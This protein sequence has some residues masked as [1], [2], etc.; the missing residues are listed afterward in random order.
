MALDIRLYLTGE[1][2]ALKAG[3][4]ALIEVLLEVAEGHLETVMPGYTHLQRAQPVTLAHHLLAYASM[5]LRDLGRLG[6]CDGRMRVSPLGAGALAGTTYP[7]DRQDVAAR[8]GL[9]GA[10]INSMDA[11]SDRDFA[12]EPFGSGDFDDASFALCR[13]DHPV[14]LL[15]AQVYD[16]GRWVFHR[17][18]HHA[19]K[20]KSRHRGTGARQDRARLRRV[21]GA[22]YHDE[23]A[24]LA[25]NK[26]MQEDKEAVFD[27][28]DTARLCLEVFAPMLKSAVFHPENMRAA[29]AQGF[30]N[31]TDCADY[32]AKKGVPFRDAYAVSGK[33]VALS[34][35]KGVTL[36]ALPLDDYKAAH[37]AF[38]GDVYEA[39]DLI[40][41]VQ[42]RRVDG[43]P[44]PQAV[45]R[46][47]EIVKERL[48]NV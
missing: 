27:A 4:K 45:R 26:D 11:V 43:G 5:L 23:G 48:L 35:E 1:I 18:V 36:E 21:D 22:S 6:D 28:V 17:I 42:Q 31:A 38:D 24:A 9:D 34:I 10:I 13:G 25:Y 7:I 30:L 15:G 41:C 29:A 47:I 2:G 3:A 14:V 33:L 37:P 19:A 8:L 40:R 44:A 39:I 12:L 46:Q 32:L 20:E 16:A